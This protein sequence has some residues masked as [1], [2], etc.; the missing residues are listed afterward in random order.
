MGKVRNHDGARKRLP[1]VLTAVY[2]MESYSAQADYLVT[3]FTVAAWQSTSFL[4][5]VHKTHI[6]FPNYHCAQD[7]CGH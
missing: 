4:L 6:Y 3:L 5:T 1:A 7:F 2:T